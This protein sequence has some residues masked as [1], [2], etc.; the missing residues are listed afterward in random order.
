MRYAFGIDGIADKWRNL[1]SFTYISPHIKIQQG[2]W[3]PPSVHLHGMDLFLQGL[4]IGATLTVMIGPITF[5]ILDSSLSGGTTHGLAAAM[6]M[7][8][9][10][11]LFISLCYFGAQTLRRSM[12]SDET[13]QAAGIIGGCVLIGLGA[14]IW[15]ARTHQTRQSPH[16]R[17]VHLSGHW[18]RG[19]LVNSFAPFS[20]VFWPTVT[21]TIVLPKTGSGAHASA[22]YLGVMSMIMLGDTLKA[23]FAGWISR[24]ISGVMMFRLRT[25]LAL[26]FMSAGVFFIA[27]ALW[28]MFID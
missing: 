21:L 23:V 20:L 27:R 25:G 10:D 18:V 1:P 13:T 16:R 14:F 26:L 12:Q 15:Y 17:I 7:W 6:G 3:Q 5:T 28:S 19:F 24:R 4:L 22:F 8:C 2:Y 11:A 9:S